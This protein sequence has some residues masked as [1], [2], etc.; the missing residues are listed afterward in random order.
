[1]FDSGASCNVMSL[2]V[3]NELNIKGTKYY[4]KCNKMDSREVPVLGCVKG[5][6]VQLVA[7]SG[8]NL[9]LDVAIV[10]C[11][12]K[13]GM[14]LSRKWAGNVGGT[15]YMDMSFSTIPI[16]GNLVNLYREKKMF[17]LIEHPNNASYEVFYV[18][19]DVDN[20]F[21]SADGK[22]HKIDQCKFLEQVGL[23]WTLLFYGAYSMFGN[24]VVIV[25]IS[26]GH[27][28]FDFSFKLNF[29]CTNNIG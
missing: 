27:E 5:L 16:E 11:P 1:M 17:H 9:K 6:V 7:Y 23:P 25:L 2:E 13:W 15:I 28:D 14:L 10:D 26:L 4:G 12:A 21:G 22:E 24:G 29:E 8:K 20:F 19:V 18:D 3:M